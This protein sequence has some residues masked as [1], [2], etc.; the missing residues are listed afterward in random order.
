MDIS[1][2][3]DPWAYDFMIHVKEDEDIYIFID[4]EKLQNFI[5]DAQA[6]LRDVDENPDCY[7]EI[8]DGN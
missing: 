1:I 5:S 4:K 7:K 2:E 8:D 6:L 3:Y